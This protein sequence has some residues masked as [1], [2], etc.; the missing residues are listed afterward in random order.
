MRM[1]LT[2]LLRTFTP[3]IPLVLTIHTEVVV[4]SQNP[5]NTLVQFGDG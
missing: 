5:T 1:P 3:N 2:L 4:A